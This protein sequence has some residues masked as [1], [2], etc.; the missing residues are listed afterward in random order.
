MGR[1]VR[2]RDL[3]PT[4]VDDNWRLQSCWTTSTPTIVYVAAA[5][6][7][8]VA[9]L[10]APSISLRNYR[11][12]NVDSKTLIE[13]GNRQTVDRDQGRGR[14]LLARGPVLRV[15]GTEVPRWVQGQSPGRGSGD[16]IPEARFP[17]FFYQKWW[18]K[19]NIYSPSLTVFKSRL[20]THLFHLANTD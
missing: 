4:H 14:V 15:W 16:F 12:A 18:I 19:L 9:R 7:C 5:A 6:T 1:A 3:Q 20:K 11:P 2:A 8:I 13:T 17:V 10:P